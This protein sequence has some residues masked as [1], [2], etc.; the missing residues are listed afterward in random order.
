MTTNQK[1]TD[2]FKTI[3]KKD[4]FCDLEILEINQQIYKATY[5]QAPYTATK[6]LTTEK[7]ETPYPPLHPK[8]AK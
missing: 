4:W 2:H 5:Q 6:T 8:N 3:I 1:L 7:P